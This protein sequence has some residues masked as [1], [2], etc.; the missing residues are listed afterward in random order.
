M[1]AVRMRAEV[2]AMSFVVA[3]SAVASP[4]VT[5]A[6]GYIDGGTAEVEVVASRIA[7]VDTEVP[8]TGVP[9]ERTVEV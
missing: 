9:I 3:A 7:G 1:M 6:I 8:I 2:V 4:A 5:A